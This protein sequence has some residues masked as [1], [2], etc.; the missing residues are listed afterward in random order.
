MKIELKEIV[1]QLTMVCNL[2]NDYKVAAII[3]EGNDNEILGWEIV[4]VYDNNTI[5]PI[6]AKV[7]ITIKDLIE[8][9]GLR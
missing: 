4:K 8:G 6:D 2:P 5:L 7:Y 9:V 1:D 3:D